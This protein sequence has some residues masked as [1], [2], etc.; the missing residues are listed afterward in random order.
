MRTDEQY[1]EMHEKIEAETSGVTV[2]VEDGSLRP[3][4]LTRGDPNGGEVGICVTSKNAIIR[5]DAYGYKNGEEDESADAEMSP[6]VITLPRD[7]VE[8]LSKLHYALGRAEVAMTQF[9]YDHD[10]R[11]PT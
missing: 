11:R 1:I 4:L 8:A 2:H 10:P 7:V 9:Y 6:V 5:F 3:L